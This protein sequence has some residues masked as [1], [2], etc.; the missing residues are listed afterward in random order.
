MIEKNL[1]VTMLSF[2]ECTI[3]KASDL[4]KKMVIDS[5][6][7]VHKEGVE[8]EPI[9]ESQAFLL[10]ERAARVAKETIDKGDKKEDTT[11]H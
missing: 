1:D 2:T 9:T 7:S 3:H 8:M 11:L 6:Y 4:L 10:F 5:V